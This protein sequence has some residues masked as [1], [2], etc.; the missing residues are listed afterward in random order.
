MNTS[1]R[2]A[3][4]AAWT[5]GRHGV[6]SGDP[7]TVKLEFSAPPEFQGHAGFWTPE[8]FFLAA[9]ATCFITT[10]RAIA[11]FSKFDVEALEVG[12]EG[13]VERGEGGFHFTRVVVR[14]LLTLHLEADRERALRLL[15][16]AERS[17]LVSRSLRSE[18]VLEPTVV[19]PGTV[20]AR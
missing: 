17:C 10:F 8:H 15:E 3:A 19:V 12:V 11:E 1:Y 6:V 13:T 7:R 20:A 2:F 5:E 9:V 14:P 18:I 16:K 4:N